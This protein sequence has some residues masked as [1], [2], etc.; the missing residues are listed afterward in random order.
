MRRLDGQQAE[1]KNV[2]S[3]PKQRL[4]RGQIRAAV[5]QTNPNSMPHNQRLSPL[6]FRLIYGLE[7]TGGIKNWACDRFDG[8]FWYALPM[9]EWARFLG[10]ASLLSFFAFWKTESTLKTDSTCGLTALGWAAPGRTGEG[11]YPTPE[12]P[13]FIAFQR[14]WDPHEGL[15]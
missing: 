2:S 13:I 15:L 9:N 6:A 5:A 12:A 11:A 4:L 1:T 8:P 7:N 14:V 10:T 3:A